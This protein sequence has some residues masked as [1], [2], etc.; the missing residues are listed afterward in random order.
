MTTAM[1]GIMYKM[2]KLTD[3]KTQDNTKGM[4]LMRIV[5]EPRILQSFLVL[6]VLLLSISVYGQPNSRSVAETDGNGDGITMNPQLRNLIEAEGESGYLFFKKDLKLAASSL[7]TTHKS[8]FNLTADDQMV[9]K[10]VEVCD[11]GMTH[12]T[13]KHYYKGIRVISSEYFTHESGGSLIKGNGRIAAGLNLPSTPSLSE[14]AALQIALSSVGANKYTWEDAAEEQWLKQFL[15]DSNETYY[16]SAELVYVYPFSTM[17]RS[18]YRLA[19]HFHINTLEPFGAWDVY[20]DALNGRVINKVSAIRYSNANGIAS[21]LYSGLR[22]IKTT[23]TDASSPHGANKYILHD[24]TRGGGVHTFD[25]RHGTSRANSVDFV[26]DDNVWNDTLRSTRQA[27]DGHW[28]GEMCYDYFKTTFAWNS[29]TGDD[30]AINIYTKWDS[31]TWS[32]AFYSHGTTGAGTKIDFFAY[33]LGSPARHTTPFTTLDIVGHEFGH[34]V[35]QYA[36]AGGTGIPSYNNEQ[37]AINE[38]FADIWGT[39]IEFYA[40]PLNANW[41]HGE[42]NHTS[43]PGYGRSLAAP[44]SVVHPQPTTYLQDTNTPGLSNQDNFW[45]KYNL[46]YYDYVL[47]PAWSGKVW[48]RGG[49]HHNNT[50]GSHWFYI[51]VNGKSSTNDKGNKFNVSGIGLTKATMITYRA[52]QYEL[53]SAPTWTQ[54]RTA[55]I[56]AAKDLYGTTKAVDPCNNEVQQVINAW[57]AVGVGDPGLMFE[58]AKTEPAAC[59]E[60]TGKAEVKV[61][62]VTGTPEYL[63]S[64]GD[65]TRQID[66]LD[67]GTYTVTVTDTSTGCSIDTTLEVEEDVNFQMWAGA[68]GPSAC[69]ESDG[70]VYV[71]LAGINGKPEIIWDPTGDTTNEV[72][73]LPAGEYTV[74]VMDTHTLC[75]ADT[76]VEIEEWGPKVII[77]GGGVRTFCEGDPIPPITL[78]A[79]ADPCAGCTYRWSTGATT[80]SIQVTAGGSYSVTATTSG[81]CTGDTST[82]LQIFLRDCDDPEEPEWEI[83]IIRSIDPNDITGPLGYGPER[84]VAKESNMEYMI[85]YENDPEFATAAALKVVIT[86][87]F[88]SNAQMFSFRLGDFG[89]GDF[90]FDVPEN[91]AFYTNRLDVSDSLGVMVDVTAGINVAQQQ[92]FWIFNS[93]DPSTGLEPLDATL[94]YL[95]VNDSITRRGEGFVN[96]TMNPKPATT[97]G[98]TIAQQAIIV[99]DINEEIPTNTWVNTIDAV[100]PTSQ[101][102]SLRFHSDSTTI[103]IRVTASDDPGGSGVGSFALYYSKDSSAFAHYGDFPADTGIYFTGDAEAVYAFFTLA[104]DNVGNTEAMKQTGEAITTLHETPLSFWN[105]QGQITYQNTAGT[106][107]SDVKIDVVDTGNVVVQS[108][109]TDAA[110]LFTFNELIQGEYQLS[111]HTDLP[112]G[113]GNA[114][115]ALAIAKY[116]AELG[117]LGI[118]EQGAADVNASGVVNATD[119]QLVASRFVDAI[120]TFAAGDWYFQGAQHLNLISDSN[121]S[122]RS[123]CFG[124]VNGSHIPATK[125]QEQYTYLETNGSQQASLNQ[126]FTLPI[127]VRRSLH[128]GSVS[129]VLEYP[130][131]TL[132]LEDVSIP[133]VPANQVFWKKSNGSLRLAWYHPE[134]KHLAAEETLLELHL[135][136]TSPASAEDLH[137]RLG[138]ESVL[139]NTQAEILS[140]E[141]LEMP[142]LFLASAISETKLSTFPNP[143][144]DRTV[145]QYQLRESARVNISIFN[146]LGEKVEELLQGEMPAG[147][148]QLGFYAGNLASGTYICKLEI[149]GKEGVR[150]L[151]T[152]M[153]IQRPEKQ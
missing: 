149:E 114:V 11:L 67:I 135:K 2:K 9:Q 32:N 66:S 78:S 98:D 60:P 26:D 74:T 39:L 86:M 106:P 42:D 90:V 150:V 44:K 79:S 85:R 108:G 17:D 107:L 76:T 120:D 35:V 51:L 87:P 145:I 144:S 103:R 100:A 43:P 71:F 56:E 53:G 72:T 133:G 68:I 25:A 45:W 36:V 124:D 130:A 7:F 109:L 101:V 102:D 34:G 46:G 123:L 3:M 152:Q 112:W 20:V 97:T 134:G 116:F 15:A 143:F 29:F 10:A 84:F 14:A 57:Y 65:T 96:F 23:K 33:G 13:Y 142:K 37:G 18:S 88:H 12:T 73:G 49:V 24:Q 99:F 81:G 47:Y 63:W 55:T 38:A 119:A 4:S 148:H 83:P 40:R 61:T 80:Q 50:I 58:D 93:I 105:L 41:L 27:Y 151:S 115:D 91:T 147:A 138:N 28:A 129:L 5:A 82:L 6:I 64:N 62:G 113:G 52:M 111:L 59:A 125:N 139:S 54:L 141:I 131:R 16:P 132:S 122:I 118:V 30:G 77:S 48:D 128:L 104:S 31:A 8:A 1:K 136:A 70:E 89:F 137:F 126:S 127:K 22:D 19:F 146:M 75:I 121:L 95:P 153:I 117:S 69:G 21:T 94:G 110:G 140:G 92:A